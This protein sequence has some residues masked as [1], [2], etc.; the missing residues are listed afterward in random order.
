MLAEKESVV[1]WLLEMEASNA[2]RFGL[3]QTGECYLYY[4]NVCFLNPLS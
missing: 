4:V 3:C 1:L 2:F